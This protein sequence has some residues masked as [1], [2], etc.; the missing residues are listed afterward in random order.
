[1]A[2][3]QDLPVDEII[4]RVA[5][6]IERDGWHQG[7]D[8]P[9]SRF[10]APYRSGTPVCIQGGCLAVF[11]LKPGRTTRQQ[12]RAAPEP[13]I[14]EVA[15]FVGEPVSIWN[16]TPG[17]TVEQV[18]AVLRTCALIASARRHSAPAQ[19]IAATGVA[20]TA[21]TCVHAALTGD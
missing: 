3:T 19:N 1:M 4:N 15:K 16:D 10:G 20:H 17:R 6:M 8:W 21:A 18:V 7:D 9:G 13:A 12:W 14:C 11:G 5:D 2:S